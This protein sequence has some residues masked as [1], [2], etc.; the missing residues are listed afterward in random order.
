MSAPFL[1]L[2]RYIMNAVGDGVEVEGRCRPDAIAD[3]YS[4]T[5]D[6]NVTVVVLNGNCSFLV[7]MPIND[8][9]NVLKHYYRY[10]SR[11]TKAPLILSIS[12][13]MGS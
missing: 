9:D 5:V 13:V 8:F 6:P 12:D 3:Y 1:L 2:P 4:G 7:G 11:N 10:L